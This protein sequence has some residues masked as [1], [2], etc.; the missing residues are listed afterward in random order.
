MHGAR[1]FASFGSLALISAFVAFAPRVSSH[2]ASPGAAQAGGE[3][4]PVD[5]PYREVFFAVLEGLYADGASTAA[6]DGLLVRNDAGGYALFV[7]GCQICTPV[8]NALLVYRAR[9]A[10]EGSKLPFDTFGPG[11]SDAD[12]A[13]CTNADAKVRFDALGRLVERWT[14][15]R[16][17]ARRLTDEERARFEI[18]MEMRRKKGMAALGPQTLGGTALTFE[19]CAS[20]DAANAASHKR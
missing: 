18:E 3:H 11:L 17:A 2:R 16:L 9:P 6:V 14:A 4:E 19:A 12:V 13:A 8:L 5:E 7:N 1:W 15:A 10:L 20:C